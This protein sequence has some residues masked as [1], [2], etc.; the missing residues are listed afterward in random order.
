MTA[1]PAL[2]SV[3]DVSKSFV[4]NDVEREVLRD[5]SFSL[6]PREFVAI[7]GASGCGKTTLLRIM[8]ALLSASSGSVRLADEVI[9][10]P[11][12]RIGYVFQQ[13]SLLPWRTVLDNVLLGPEI[14]RRKRAAREAAL[15]NIDAVGLAGFEKH[16]PHQLSGGMRQRVNLARALTQDPDV[17]IMDEPFAALDS[18]T[19]E[20]MQVE[21][22]R[23]WEL[24]RKSVVL[25][26]HQIDEAVMLA[27]RVLVFS[28][29]PGRLREQ[30]SIEL[31]RPRDL[32][33]KRSPE[34]VG[35]VD[36]IWSMIEDEVGKGLKADIA[37]RRNS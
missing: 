23:I 15:A 13:D 37:A 21:L 2:L 33:L 6:R 35:Y 5:V 29:A 25:V 18:Q 24:T 17:L 11:H 27:D 30:V 7:V 14:Q 36:A 22:L 20:L 32:A 4:S 16:Y 1:P 31:P 3:H 26:T 34:F 19:R 8:G 28:V 12:P 10:R 9:T